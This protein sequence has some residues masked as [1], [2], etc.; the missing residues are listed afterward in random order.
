[1][2]RVRFHGGRWGL[3]VGVAAL[4]WLVFPPAAG[5]GS[6]LGARVLGPLLFNGMLLSLFWLLLA[7][8]RRETYRELREMSFLAG[9]L[10]AV[11]ILA[12][13][14]LRLF[15]DR[16]EV[17]PVPLAA[18]LVTVLYNGRFALFAA[19][20]L[21]LLLGLQPDLRDSGA[22][23]FGLA[24]GIAAALGTRAVRRRSEFYLPLACIALAQGLASVTLGLMLDWG[25]RAIVTSAIVG[26][27]GAAWVSLAMILLPFAETLTRIT[28][29]LTLLELSDPGRPLLR[30]LAVE[31]PGTY[32]H[33]VTMASLCESAC[34]AIGANG[35]LAR[36][37]CDYHDV[38]KLKAPQ[39]FVENQLQGVNPHDRLPPEESARIIRDHVVHGIELAKQAGLPRVIQNFIPEH[40]GTSSLTYFAAR[41]GEGSGRPDLPTFSYPGPRPRSAETAV[42]MLADSAEAAVR[43]LEN[44]TPEQVREAIVH[45]VGQ[46]LATGQLQDA[47]LTL[48]DLDRVTVAFAR[49]LSGMH[50]SRI[51]YPERHG[52][53]PAELTHA[54]RP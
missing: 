2:E 50:H 43:V 47:P 38:G 22:V 16:P 52:G 48:W 18:I 32:A 45:L 8:Y 5:A 31:A 53:I 24:G 49:Q 46:K 27:V 39:F 3:L 36:V 7:F 14:W 42:A 26:V 20:A 30:R 23:L 28:T 54:S 9:L 4:T 34:D 1:M 11:V 19:T 12:G 6:S 10:A 33:S 17:L 44:P 13:V 35:L 21:A 37:G 29:D 41:A 25:A 51:N 15:A 40:H